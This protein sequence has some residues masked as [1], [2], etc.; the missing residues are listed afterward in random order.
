MKFSTDR[1]LTTHAGTLP[2][3]ADLKEM[4]NAQ[5]AGKAID[6]GVFAKRVALA[7]GDIVK[8]QIACGLDIINDGELGKSNFS[9]YARDRL[10]GF[11]EREVKAGD[12]ASTI[13]A[14]DLSEFGDYFSARTSHRGDNLRR[15]FCNQPL[16]Y[17][18]HDS[19]TA[20]IADFKAALQ[21]QN[22]EEAFLPAI[23]PGTIEHWMKN[24]YYPNDEAYLAAIADAMHEEY[25]AIVDAGF[26]LQID[27]PDLPDGWQFMS[28]MTVPEYRKYAEL[29]VEALNH[30]LRDIPPDRVRFHT[31]WG[32]YH[33]PHKYDI[34][35]RDIIDL[36]LKVK[37]NT[38]SIEAANPRHE[39]EWRV[40]EEV[41]L[42][43]GKV[44]VPGVVGHA[45]DI[46]EHPQAI[47]DRLVRYAKIVGRE[48]L[49]GGTD[50]GLGPRVGS[51]QICWA[52][53]EALTE[54]ARLASKE[55]W[56][57]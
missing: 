29:R 32:S 42:P 12:Q 26:L 40:W 4:H 57:R 19:L 21:G 47:A 52:K 22:Y 31:C 11:I 39:H 37:A 54:G 14:R 38:I 49:M 50:C 56:V 3:P 45:T 41:K 16:K 1:I 28:K 13:Y 27:D 8:R 55:L 53:I 23:A 30:G 43:A 24:D 18:G 34:P 46:V 51:A 33:G 2:Q 25:R 35:L 6:L 9:R 20:E 10:S 36:I 48:N 15:V 17:V 44:L 5:V 7:V